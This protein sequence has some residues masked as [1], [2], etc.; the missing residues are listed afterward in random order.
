MMTSTKKQSK[1]EAILSGKRGTKSDIA[2]TKKGYQSVRDP[3]TGKVTYTHILVAEKRLGRKLKANE[4]VDHK[5][6]NKNDNRPG[7]LRVMSRSKNTQLMHERR[8]KKK[9]TKK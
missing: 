3:K 9:G 6:G 8:D 4:T 5:N 1:G 7:N 2:H